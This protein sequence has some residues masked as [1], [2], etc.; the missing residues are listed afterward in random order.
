MLSYA[1]GGSGPITAV[2]HGFTLHHSTLIVW[3]WSPGWNIL[4]LYI[5]IKSSIL[6]TLK[7]LCS[8]GCYHGVNIIE[9][10]DCKMHIVPNMTVTM[11][12]ASF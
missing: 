9:S 4:S 5:F 7:Y 1:E 6:T 2:H 12:H 10:W 11:L 8:L 3:I